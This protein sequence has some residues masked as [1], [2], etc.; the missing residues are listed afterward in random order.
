M[1]VKFTANEPNIGIFAVPNSQSLD[2][3]DCF[4][5]GWNLARCEYPRKHVADIQ[6]NNGDTNKGMT[7]GWD[8]RNQMVLSIFPQPPVIVPKRIEEKQP[9]QKGF[10][11]KLFGK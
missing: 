11:R 9:T 10:F 3:V 4:M 2:Y 5:A 1:K 8:A 6:K 7:D